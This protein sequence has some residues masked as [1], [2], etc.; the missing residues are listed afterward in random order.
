MRQIVSDYEV[1][2][3]IPDGDYPFAGNSVGKKNIV[4]YVFGDNAAPRTLLDIGFGL[5]DLARI[6]KSD[7]KT[8]HWHIDGVD[9]F[10][11]ACCNKALFEKK[12]YRNIW[13]GL[14]QE[15]GQERLA[16]Y[17]IICLFDVIEH[18]DPTMARQLLK[19]LLTALGPHSR[20]ALSTPL[21][22]W[23]QNHM[24]PDDLEEHLIGVPAQSLLLLQPQMYLI[25]SR[26]LVGTF[27]FGKQSLDLL[28]HFVP[29]TDRQFGMDAGRAHLA[30]LGIPA[31]DVLYMTPHR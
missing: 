20:L 8:A 5:G 16:Q 1:V 15:I 27:V 6:V 4:S 2:V 21:F 23:P 22:F 31:D 30:A 28:D 24:N 9:G 18:L 19:D 11:V 3:D 26:F 10:H 13:H 25:D 7:P 12:H 29:T 14:A 17:D